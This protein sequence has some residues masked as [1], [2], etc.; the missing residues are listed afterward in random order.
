MEALLPFCGLTRLVV[1]G[2]QFHRRRMEKKIGKTGFVE[3]RSFWNIFRSFDRLWIGYLL[4]LQVHIRTL[5]SDWGK[6]VE[7]R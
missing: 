1:I 6:F 2:W 7:A 4:V 5:A 3:Q